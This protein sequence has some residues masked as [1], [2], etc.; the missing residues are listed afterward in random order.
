MKPASNG[1]LVRR[2]MAEF[3]IDTGLEPLSTHP[4]RYLW[5][6]SFAV[7]NFLELFHQTDDQT[8]LNLALGL[9]DQVHHT[10]GRHRSD[11]SAKGWISGLG[12]N[13]GKSR[14]TRGGLRIGKKLPERQPGEPLDESLEWDR[15]GQYYHYLTKW[16]HALNQ[17]GKAAKDP[18]Y[19]LWAM[20]L[21]KTAHKSFTYLP[22]DGHTRM[23]WKMS[24]DLRRPLIS[25]M[26]Q[27]DPLDG[28]ITYNEVEKTAIADFN[29]VIPLDLRDE[30]S[31][32]AKICEGLNWVTADPLGIG[33]LLFDAFR[34]AQ[35]MDKGCSDFTAVLESLV[36]SVLIGMEY[37]SKENPLDF[38]AEYRL[39]FREL[40]LSIGLRGVEKL[41]RLI[42]R[43]PNILDPENSL[44]P[45]VEVLMDYVPLGKRIEMFWTDGK[46][47]QSTSWNEHREINMVMLATSLAPDGFFMI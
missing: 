44:Q 27:H 22:S 2:I 25:A 38:P 41:L 42:K 4:K 47:R 33:G 32:M 29:A 19:I 30:I 18:K 10:L 43:S 20:E 11:A 15:D 24:I 9:V 37:Y 36:D 35:L 12:E 8:Y 45:K 46:H 1:K 7:C 16:M 17:A 5:T 34:I 26:G 40:G 31:D 39:A 13:E 3:V 28:F 14:P 23:F 6:D 21:A